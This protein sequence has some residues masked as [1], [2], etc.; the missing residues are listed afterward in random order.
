MRPQAVTHPAARSISLIG[1]PV[2]LGASARGAAMGPAALRV[3]GLAE[4]LAELGHQVQDQGD[5]APLAS[6][7]GRTHDPRIRHA[8]A[9]AAWNVGV[10]DA[11]AAA[12]QA[13]SAPVLLGGDHSLAIGSVSAAAAH[14]AAQGLNLVVLW[15]DA[16]GDYNTQLTSPSGNL[17][18]MPVAFLSGEPGLSS[19]LPGRGFPAVPHKAFHLFGLR[20]IDRSER[21]ALASDGLNCVD[22]RMI[23]EFGVSALMRDMLST[24]DPERTHLHVS[25]DLDACDPSIAPGVGTPVDGGLT[26]R[27]AHLAMELIHESGLMGSLD[28]VEV[29]PFLD[30]RGRTAKLAVDLAGSLFGRTVLARRRGV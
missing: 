12:L 19:L 22:M 27:E 9:L 7:G 28:I 25:L 5:V 29:N 3:A 2:D 6:G 30:D 16:H 23:D 14:A 10:H 8:E 18:G 13:G 26:Y 17:H 1:A 11:M 4:H 24:L 20:S 15:V 21:D